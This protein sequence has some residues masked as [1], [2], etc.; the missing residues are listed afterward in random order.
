MEEEGGRAP[1][2]ERLMKREQQVYPGKCKPIP[3][4]GPQ[5]DTWQVEATEVGSCHNIQPAI[6]RQE[7]S[8][9]DVRRATDS[10]SVVPGG[11]PKDQLPH[12]PWP[13]SQGSILSDAPYKKLG[14]HTVGKQGPPLPGFLLMR[15]RWADF[16][17]ISLWERDTHTDKHTQ[18]HREIGF[19]FL[20]GR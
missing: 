6:L 17:F 18:R 19:Y 10:P 2:Q 20:S 13:C 9:G 7:R 14:H 8:W 16:L 5:Q 1:R 3:E 4:T 12:C 15:W 11:G